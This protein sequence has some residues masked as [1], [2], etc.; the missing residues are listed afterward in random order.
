MSGA[1]YRD[2]LPKPS[3]RDK[4]K[5]S[6]A[7]TP[8]PIDRTELWGTLHDCM[9]ECAHVISAIDTKRP[10]TDQDWHDIDWALFEAARAVAASW[11][12]L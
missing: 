8:R 4:L 5:A 3:L 9:T 1:F 10:I 12:K 2:N 6:I 11:G 7:I